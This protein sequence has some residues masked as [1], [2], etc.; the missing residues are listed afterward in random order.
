MKVQGSYLFDADAEA[1][2]NALQSPE[3]LSSCIPGSEEFQRTGPDA[4]DVAMRLRVAA[5]SG[6]YRGH[7]TIE[8]KVH[9]KSYRMKVAG[10]GAAGSMRSEVSF[11]FSPE[12]GGTRIELSGDAHVSGVMARVGQRLMGAASRML[13]NQFF[14]CMKSRVEGDSS[15]ASE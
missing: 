11:T 7:I 4:Y 13:M 8:D 12:D 9:L 10:K 2:W 14:D 1:V 3:V 15:S 5:V 6:S